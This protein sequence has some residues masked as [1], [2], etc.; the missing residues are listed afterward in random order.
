MTSLKNS[1][2]SK[3]GQ[4]EREVEALTKENFKLKKKQNFAVINST[5]T[6]DEVIENGLKFNN[7]FKIKNVNKVKAMT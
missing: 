3:K 6:K 2:A 7:S 4:L 5:I 1:L